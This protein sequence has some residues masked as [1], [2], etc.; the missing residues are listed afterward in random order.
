MKT[1]YNRFLKVAA[2][3]GHRS[4]PDGTLRDQERLL[5]GRRQPKRAAPRN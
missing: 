5:E 3:R 4:A 1:P 2:Q